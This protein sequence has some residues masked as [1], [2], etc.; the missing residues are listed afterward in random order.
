MTIKNI[1]QLATIVAKH[2]HETPAFD[3]NAFR[4]RISSGYAYQFGGFVLI[5]PNLSIG[6]VAPPE[7][8]PVPGGYELRFGRKPG[9][10]ASRP[11]DFGRSYQEFTPHNG[12]FR[13]VTNRGCVFDEWELPFRQRRFLLEAVELGFR[14]GRLSQGLLE[15]PQATVRRKTRQPNVVGLASPTVVESA[16]VA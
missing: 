7:L 3:Y 6:V 8:V 15:L 10:Q 13:I 1:A 2:F 9:P 4:D 11:E 16:R 14:I 12:K 5:L